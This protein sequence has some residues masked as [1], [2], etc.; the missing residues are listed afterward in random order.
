L[1][2]SVRRA[3]GKYSSFAFL[4]N[5]KKEEREEVSDIYQLLYEIDIK[6]AEVRKLTRLKNG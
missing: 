4:A 5:K 6:V 3:S 1:S 2:S